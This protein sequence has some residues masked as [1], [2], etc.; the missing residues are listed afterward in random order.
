MPHTLS[1]YGKC[2]FGG[3]LACGVTHTAVVPLD[4]VKVKMQVDP[5]TY[6]SLPQGMRQVVAT[7][8][9]R[10]LTTGWLPTAIGYSAQGCFKFGLNEVFKDVYSNAVGEENSVKYRG[11]VWVAASG[12]A[13][14]FA[15][16]ALSPMEMVKVKVQASKPGTFPTA[17]GPALREM[18]RNR[19]ETR[20]PF[21]SLRPL[22]GRQIPYT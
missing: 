12:S 22:W 17:F 19:S 16:I 2:L 10:G 18:N 13:E 15:D 8:G 20:F 14:F 5:G 9:S 11:L 4:V 7:E 6:R 3:V 1:Y 21:G